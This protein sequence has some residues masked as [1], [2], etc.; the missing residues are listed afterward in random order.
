MDK[1]AFVETK[2]KK[3]KIDDKLEVQLMPTTALTMLAET[4]L[5]VSCCVKYRRNSSSIDS[6]TPRTS[7]IINFE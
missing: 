5:L 4:S 7:L 3:K 2:I 1:Q 6:K